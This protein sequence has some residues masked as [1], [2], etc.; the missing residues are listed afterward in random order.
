[1]DSTGEVE[2]RRKV[3]SLMIHATECY[4]KAKNAIVVDEELT[5]LK[6]QNKKRAGERM[7]YLASL[8]EAS[9]KNYLE[10]A[11]HERIKKDAETKSNSQS[12][13]GNR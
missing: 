11:E 9:G 12:S 4:T 10:I 6:H 7:L 5:I 3:D 8:L 1:M 13:T 2:Q